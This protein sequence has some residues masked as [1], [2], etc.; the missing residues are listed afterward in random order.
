MDPESLIKQ[1]TLSVALQTHTISAEASHSV[2]FDDLGGEQIV[3]SW[4]LAVKTSIMATKIRVDEHAANNNHGSNECS[5]V[6]C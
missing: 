2:M 3:P 6:A 5:T 4:R 1:F